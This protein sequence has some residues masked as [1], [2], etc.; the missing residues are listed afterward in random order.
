[1]YK[2]IVQYYNLDFPF[3]HKSESGI[4]WKLKQ[5]RY[6]LRIITKAISRLLSLNQ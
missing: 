4:R 3:Y 1:M 2:P 6:T 5:Y